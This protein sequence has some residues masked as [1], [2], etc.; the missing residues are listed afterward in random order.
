MSQSSPFEFAIEDVA[1]LAPVSLVG[2]ECV[3]QPFEFGIMVRAPSDNAAAFE[4]HVGR[5]ASLSFVS[6]SGA[7]RTLT[8]VI[9]RVELIERTADGALVIRYGFGPRFANLEERNWSRVHANLSVPRAIARVLDEHGVPHRFEL[10]S[11]YPE[12]EYQVQ[13]QESDRAFVERIAAEV[14]LFYY[15]AASSEGRPATLVFA[16]GNA[17]LRAVDAPSELQVHVF[18]GSAATSPALREEQVASFQMTHAAAPKSLVGFD[19]D[20]K[21]PLHGLREQASPQ[22]GMQALPALAVLAEFPIQPGTVYEHRSDTERPELTGGRATAVLDQWQHHSQVASCVAGSRLLA[23]GYRFAL[24]RH[25]VEGLSRAYVITSVKHTAFAEESAGRTAYQA[26]LACVADS[27]VPRPPRPPRRVVQVT[28]SA[29][30][31]GPRDQ[32]IHTDE[33]GRVRIQFHWDSRGAVELASCFVRVV[34]PWS[35]EGWGFQFIPRI[36]MEVLVTFLQGDPDVPIVM[37]ALPNATHPPPFALPEHKSKSG[38]KTRSTPHGSGH[39]ELSFE[40]AVG[41]ERIFVRAERDLRGEVK[42]NRETF[43]GSDDALD[44]GGNLQE[45]VHGLRQTHVR[46]PWTAHAQASFDASV[47]SE[48][49]V[50]SSGDAQLNGQRDVSV[51]A[52]QGLVLEADAVLRASAG[53]AIRLTAGGQG[54]IGELDLQSEGRASI[55]ATRDIHIRAVDGLRLVCGT[56]QIELRDGKIRI[57]ADDIELGGRKSVQA[58]GDGPSLKLAKEAEIIGST[59]NIYSEHAS[60]E[61]TREAHVRGERVALEGPFEKEASKGKDGTDPTKALDISFLDE[62]KQPYENATYVLRAGGERYQGN[63]TIDG[64]L[65]AMVPARAESAHIT[66]WLDKYPEGRRKEFVV[67][68]EALAPAK[69][70]RG[71]KQRLKMLGYFKGDIDDTFDSELTSALKHFQQTERLEMTGAL[72]AETIAELERVFGH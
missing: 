22:A 17:R 67:A 55:A 10:S 31:V 23:P 8:G 47:A 1:D 5:D 25:P 68:I 41:A 52:E 15:F 64:R 18:E 54:A 60:V 26:E 3:S 57:V 44:I 50:M 40:D 45:R 16:D 24:A 53:R 19:Y 63:L 7:R 42:R 69:T 20:F 43:V 14:G 35:G 6:A 9:R 58:T 36:G 33:H 13:Y 51:R 21:R 28:E 62:H 65:R 71:A 59:V 30:V 34:Q 12:R 38:I 11:E 37:G 4:P 61:L 46:G 49:S 39:N 70:P 32:E 72:D 48:L 66:L 56:S 2:R 29:V 27:V